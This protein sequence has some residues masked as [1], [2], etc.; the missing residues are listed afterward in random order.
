M[1]WEA[2]LYNGT[3]D[4]IFGEDYE[5]I[6]YVGVLALAFPLLTTSLDLRR[7]YLNMTMRLSTKPESQNR[8]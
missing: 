6:A 5:C 2:I 7:G 3:D 8:T 1:W 4:Q